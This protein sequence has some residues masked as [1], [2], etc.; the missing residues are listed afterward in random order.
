MTYPTDYEEVRK[1][2]VE[3]IM[4]LEEAERYIFRLE[5]EKSDIVADVQRFFSENRQLAEQISLANEK[6]KELE[7]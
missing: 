4:K 2:L 7:Y 5:S 6:I 1:E 3:M